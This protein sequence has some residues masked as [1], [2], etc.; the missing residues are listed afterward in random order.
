MRCYTWYQGSCKEALF[1]IDVLV[2]DGLANVLGLQAKRRPRSVS[3]FG[4]KSV[5]KDSKIVTV[6]LESTDGGT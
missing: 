6:L 4:A 1:W 3:V 5:V 2:R